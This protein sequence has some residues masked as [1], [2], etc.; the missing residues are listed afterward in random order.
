MCSVDT[1]YEG[2]PLKTL[3]GATELTEKTA[4]VL[5]ESL[6]CQHPKCPGA[7]RRSVNSQGQILGHGVGKCY[8]VK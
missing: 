1:L 7:L 2:F 3:S 4:F 6:Q 5:V 8:R